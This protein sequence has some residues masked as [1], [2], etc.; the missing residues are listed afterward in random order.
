MNCPP[1]NI[2]FEKTIGIRPS[3]NNHGFLLYQSKDNKPITID[4]LT[5]C[6]QNNNCLS[7]LLSYKES[8]CF[9]YNLNFNGQKEK[10]LLLDGDVVL[11]T[12]TCIS[13]GT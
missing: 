1:N 2:R 5:R 3:D 10:E 9:A 13:D 6:M 12:K 7:F 4:C 8:S 11:F